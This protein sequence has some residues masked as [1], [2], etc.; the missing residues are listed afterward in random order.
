LAVT[1]LCLTGQAVANVADLPRTDSDFSID[2]VLDEVAWSSALRVDLDV[3]TDPGEN[4]EAAVATRAF[5]IED[6]ENLYVAFEADDPEPQAIRAY[7]RDRDTAWGDDYVGILLDTFNDE[8]RAFEFYVNALGVQMDKIHD[9]TTGGRQWEYDASWDAIWDSAGQVTDDGYIVEIRIP[10]SQLRFPDADGVKTWGFNLKRIYP[11]DRT[12]RFSNNSRDRDRSCLLCQISK[13]RGLE[14]S[15]PSRDIEIVPTLTASWNSTTE[16]PGFVPLDSADAE[17][18]AGVTMRWGITPDLTASFTVNPDYS[19]IEADVAQLDV[20]T[21]FTLFFPEK[22]PFFLEG[23]NYF[24]T[25]IDAVFTR[26]ISSP[27]VGMKLTG[28]RGHSTF[29]VIAAQDEVTNLLFPDVYGSETDYIEDSNTAFVG[30]YS[31]GFDGTSSL[32]AL[33]TVREG[34]DYHNYVAGVDGRWKINDQ[35]SLEFQH[36]ESTTEYPLDLAIEYEQPLDE[37]DGHATS[38]EYEYDSRAWSGEIRVEDSSAGF[39]SDSGFVQRVGGTQYATR[40]GR[41]YYGGTDDWWTRIR[42][43]LHHNWFDEED[44]T[45]GTRDTRLRAGIGG[46]WQSWTQLHLV[47]GKERHEGVLYDKN[48]VNLFTEFIPAAGLELMFFVSI[49]DEVDYSNDRQ[50]K[51]RW[52]EQTSNWNIS[53]NLLLRLQS[54]I[55]SLKTQDDERVFDAALVDSRLTWQFSVR[56]FLRL[57]VQYRDVERNPDVYLEEVEEREKSVGRQLLYSY[58]LN[59]QTVFFV[60][61]SDRYLDNDNLDSLTAEDRTWF[62]KVGY[63]WTP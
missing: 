22:R 12:Y 53:R 59:P 63:A 37:F 58:K 10:L 61:Y 57:T 35:H 39:R 29:G 36:L 17:V 31:Y 46:P 19:Q 50:G 43:N 49:G 18:D 23:S 27:D 8:R 6:G 13:L 1:Y 16:D 9:D 62:M 25:P 3:E 32:G 45:L 30:R 55:S 52:I 56:S 26:T 2:G 28:K 33:V 42:I 44:G 11:R 24:Q 20:N 60:G 15:R 34:S 7:L 4:L 51:I 48:R 54:T 5:L 41:T 47:E 21:E 38:F 14:A 40:I